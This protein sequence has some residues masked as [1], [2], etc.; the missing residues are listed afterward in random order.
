MMT[1]C[2]LYL[3]PGASSNPLGGKYYEYQQKAK[4]EL[5]YEAWKNNKA[6]TY[7]PHVTLTSFFQANNAELE[8]LSNHIDGV[9]EKHLAH[10][11]SPM[12]RFK[13]LTA[14][15]TIRIEFTQRDE[16]D[17]FLEELQSNFEFISAK[18]KLH[19][20]LAYGSHGSIEQWY[21]KYREL[22]HSLFSTEVLE[23]GGRK[24]WD[25]C[26][27]RTD[28]DLTQFEAIKTWA[29]NSGMNSSQAVDGEKRVHSAEF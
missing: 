20:S 29:P 15:K 18:S 8:R 4:G 11:E 23:E 24:P 6:F 16:L 27:W 3:N 12:L 17:Q 28:I 9:F 26:L 10:L 19:M 5:G 25:I 2:I 1:Q 7:P 21:D 13:Q 14:E 22:A